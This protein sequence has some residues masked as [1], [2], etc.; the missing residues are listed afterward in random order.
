MLLIKRFYR[1]IKSSS[2]E[3]KCRIARIEVSR[4]LQF[5]KFDALTACQ[6]RKKKNIF[7]KFCFF[8]P[9]F[10]LIFLHFVSFFFASITNYISCFHGFGQKLA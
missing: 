7:V 1:E 8:L 5:M 6:K 10:C 3:K 2:L 4:G 9:L